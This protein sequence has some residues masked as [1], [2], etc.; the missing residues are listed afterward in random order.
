MFFSFRQEI[1]GELRYK[2]QTHQTTSQGKKKGQNTGNS[3][4]REL[5]ER[6]QAKVNQQPGCFKVEEKKKKQI[7]PVRKI[8]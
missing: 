5:E 1:Q 6:H 2:P 8:Q 4:N 7:K 3:Q